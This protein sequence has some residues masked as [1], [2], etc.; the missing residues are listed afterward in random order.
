MTRICLFV[1]LLLLPILLF[2]QLRN[3]WR[4]VYDRDGRLNSMKFYIEGIEMPDSTTYFQY[5]T[6]NI[7][8]GIIKGEITPGKGCEDGQVWLFSELGEIT[9]YSIRSKG[10]VVF[11]IQKDSEG[12]FFSSWN[13]PFSSH[14]V[15]WKGIDISVSGDKLFL[16]NVKDMSAA[17]FDPVIPVDLSQKFRFSVLV[18]KTD[19]NAQLGVLLGW[20]DP[21]NWLSVEIKDGTYFGVN[22]NREGKIIELAGFKVIEK[23]NKAQ[24]LITLSHSNNSIVIEINQNIETIIQLPVLPGNLIGLINRSKS[25]ASF[26]EMT[27]GYPLPNTEAFYSA[28]WF[29]IGTGLII[30][31][32]GRIMTT[33]DAI[34]NKRDLRVKGMINGQYYIALV[35]VLAFEEDHNLAILQIVPEQL[36]ALAGFPFGYLD[37]KPV[38]ESKIYSMGFPHAVSGIWLPSTHFEGKVLPSGYGGLTRMAELPFRFGMVGSPVFDDYLNFI[39]IISGKGTTLAYTEIVDFYDNKRIFQALLK[40]HSRSMNSTYKDQ[41]FGEKQKRINNNLVIIEAALIGDEYY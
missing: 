18:P 26:E 8:K 7:L 31:D 15:F 36:P 12:H 17:I 40:T 2:G 41:S 9:S 3:G 37:R 13:D 29:G 22:L 23:Q 30:S 5:Y 34:E 1:S 35:E 6:D 10:Q 20:R 11:S 14:S 39:G 28:N 32:D 19:Y 27:F 21:E 33:C 25:T 4:S 24:N 38:S 16:N